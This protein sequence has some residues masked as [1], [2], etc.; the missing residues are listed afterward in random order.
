MKKLVLFVMPMLVGL[1]LVAQRDKDVPA[2]GK[3]EKVDLE[4]KSCDFDKDAEA[5]VLFDVAELYLD[6]T[7]SLEISMERH[8]RIKILKDKG[9]NKADIH[10]RF[11]S[12]RNDES[13]K[14]LTAQTYTMDGSG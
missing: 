6:F 10:L 2:F 14:N 9:L 8:V 12:Y 5:V 3:V 13:I 1:T 4:L 7:S 11:H